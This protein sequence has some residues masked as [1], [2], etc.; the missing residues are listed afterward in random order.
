ME[1]VSVCE[2]RKSISFMVIYGGRAQYQSD[3]RN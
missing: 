3:E 2:Q 1:T